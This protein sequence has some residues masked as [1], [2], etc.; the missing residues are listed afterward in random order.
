MRRE[1]PKKSK[2]GNKSK[3][4]QIQR[5]KQGDPLTEED[6]KMLALVIRYYDKHGYSPA[7]KDMPN[8]VAL[9]KRFGIWKNVLMVAGVP[10]L[11]DPDCMHKRQDAIEWTKRVN[12]PN[13]QSWKK[14]KRRI[15]NK[16]LFW[17]PGDPLTEDD[18]ELLQTVKQYYMEHGYSPS[19]ADISN[20]EALKQRFRLWK[21]VLEACGLPSLNDK[22][23]VMLRTEAAEKK[24]KEINQ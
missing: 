1:D 16:E 6:H 14:A 20:Q 8:S 17:Q 21:D 2:T 24:R 15:N 23:Q 9:K 5:W 7:Q 22:R 10:I 13:Y 3:Q 11:N 19:K 4:N 18:I 12:N